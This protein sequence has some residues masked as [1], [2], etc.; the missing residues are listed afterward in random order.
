MAATRAAR[1]SRVSGELTFVAT[2]GAAAGR[3]RDARAA[4]SGVATRC[5]AGRRL[6]ALQQCCEFQPTTLRRWR[7]PGHCYSRVSDFCPFG[8]RKPDAANEMSAAVVTIRNRST[9]PTHR[10]GSACCAILP[11]RAALHHRPPAGDDATENSTQKRRTSASG[12]A[13]L[14]QGARQQP[15]VAET[16]V[17]HRIGALSRLLAVCLRRQR[18][19]RQPR[20]DRRLKNL[21]ISRILSDFP[22]D[23][24]AEVLHF[25]L[26]CGVACVGSAASLGARKGRHPRLGLPRRGLARCS[27]TRQPLAHGLAPCWARA[28]GPTSRRATT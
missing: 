15:T 9:P 23:E 24:H 20:R 11:G 6:A 18:A 3:L 28:T 26:W 25:G 19:R 12:H 17:R 16:S 13:R 22:E 8:G 27:P 14:P 10:A 7:P 4:L 2:V 21:D 5:D 1:R